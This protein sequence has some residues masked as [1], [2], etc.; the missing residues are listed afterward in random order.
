VVSSRT[1]HRSETSLLSLGS[2]VTVTQMTAVGKVKTHESVMGSHDSLINLEVG[3]AAA[4]ALNIDTPLLRIHMESLESTSL[5][6]QL[7]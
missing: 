7:N 3:R 1:F 6:G 5:A 2:L 4:Q